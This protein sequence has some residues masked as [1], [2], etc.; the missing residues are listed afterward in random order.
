M[1]G[2]VRLFA[3]R[4]L[5]PTAEEIAGLVRVAQLD[6]VVEVVALPDLHLKPQLESP[7]STAVATRDAIVLGLSSPSPGCGMA[8]AL[9]PLGEAEVTPSRLDRLFDHLA[10]RLTPDR[11]APSLSPGEL[12][13]VLL[14][15]AA[16]A[17]ERFDLDPALLEAVEGQGDALAWVAPDAGDEDVL[18]TIP[19]DF[20]PLAAREFG[21]IGRGNHFFEVQVVEELL[22]PTVA[23]RWGVQ[24]G[25]VVAMYH[26]DSGHL[27][28]YLGRLYAHRRK[29]TW[30]GRLREW[31]YKAAFHR[32]RAHSPGELWRRGH[33]YFVPR[34]FTPIPTDGPEAQE[35]LR[36]LAAAT[37]YAFANRIAVL[38]VLRDAL[39]AVWGDQMSPPTLLCDVTHNGIRP[40][41]MNGERLW[42]HRHNASRALPPGHPHL[43]GG[44][45]AETGQ[46]LLLPGTNRTGSYLCVAQSGVAHSLYSVDHGAGRSAVRLGREEPHNGHVTRLYHYRQ[47]FVS[48]LPHI[49]NTG[50]DEVLAILRRADLA[51]PVA[52]LR[53]LAVLKDNC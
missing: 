46:P 15:G 8:L 42:V 16:A 31:R 7:S 38:A 12:E 43:A 32:A 50:V 44:P 37:N 4:R 22:E 9:T 39:Q 23:A 29:N 14:R 24:R 52:R 28:A 6:E 3:G 40:E 11:D 18:V 35:C 48:A 27:G 49:S 1:R 5:P 47:G 21:M 53:P 30:A 10:R 17:V 34:R 45:F 26:A 41:P 2:P 25:Q 33:Y 36:A 13:A 51:Q 19:P 20:L